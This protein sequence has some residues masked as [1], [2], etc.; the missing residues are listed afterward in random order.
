MPKSAVFGKLRTY[1]E[2]HNREIFESDLAANV[3]TADDRK[4]MAE[5]LSRKS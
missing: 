1:L 5:I 4:A 3:L 2:V